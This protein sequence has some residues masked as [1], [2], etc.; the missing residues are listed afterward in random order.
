MRGIPTSGAS[1]GGVISTDVA[2][3]HIVIIPRAI[4]QVS[5]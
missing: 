5:S 3:I 2:I 1:S 4:A